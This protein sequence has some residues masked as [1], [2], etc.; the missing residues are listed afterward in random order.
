M[1]AFIVALALFVAA[2][3]FLIDNSSNASG[4]HAVSVSVHDLTTNV[5]EYAGH[6]VVTTGTLSYDEDKSQYQV[7]ADGNY[8]ILIK[9]FG[10]PQIL[11]TMAG[12]QVRV[13]GTFGSSPT[14]G[15]YIIADSVIE[16]ITE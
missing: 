12:K 9:D 13:T 14:D 15:T 7:V 1:Y 3:Y 5:E 10:D 16:V 6:D 4:S 11:L 2:N 8:A